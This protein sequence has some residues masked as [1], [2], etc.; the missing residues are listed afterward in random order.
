MVGA[1]VVIRGSTTGVS[2]D[3][4]GRFAIEARE[5]EVLSVSF[6]G[7]TPQTITLGAKTMLTL[8]LR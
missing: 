5:G 1:S 6:V 8:T 3:I 4:D 7:Y 2:S